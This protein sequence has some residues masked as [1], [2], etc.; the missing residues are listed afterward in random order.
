MTGEHDDDQDHGETD[1]C[2]FTVALVVWV[3]VWTWAGRKSTPGA[4]CASVALSLLLLGRRAL[5]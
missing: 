5:V 2:L 3:G 4:A 1:G